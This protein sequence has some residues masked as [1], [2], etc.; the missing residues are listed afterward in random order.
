MS[1][2]S[3]R[4]SCACDADCW[5]NVHQA[6]TDG[7]AGSVFKAEVLSRVAKEPPG[8]TLNYTGTVSGKPL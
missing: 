4:S 5:G 3:L 8:C 7:Q 6:V 1:L 2:L